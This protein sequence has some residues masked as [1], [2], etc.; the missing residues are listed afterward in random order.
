MVSR[1]AAKACALAS[2]DSTARRTRPQMSSSQDTSSGN[3]KEL[4]G[5][6]FEGVLPKALA[7]LRKRL[8]DAPA[9]TVGM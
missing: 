9:V 5:P 4:A 3:R 1:S 6:T 7:E 8:T 2:L